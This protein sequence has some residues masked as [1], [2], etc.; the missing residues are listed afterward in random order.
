M[1]APVLV[2]GAGPAGL[3]VAGELALAGV[4]AVVIDRL[5]APDPHAPGQAINVSTVELLDERGLV[6]GLRATT[7]ALPGAHFSLLWLRPDGLAESHPHG[8][9]APQALVEAALAERLAGSAVE[10]R[11]GHLLTGLR[12]DATGVTARLRGPDG[13]YDLRGSYLVG[14]DGEDSTVRRLAGIGFPG[15]GWS[16]SGIVGDIGTDFATLPQVHLGA[17]FSEAGGMYSGSP[18]GPGVLR[19]ITAA[20]DS[21]QRTGS[22]PATLDELQ[23]EVARLTGHLLPAR[24]LLWAERFTSTTGNAERYRD[25]RVFLVGDAAHTF[26]PLG[27]L[28]LNT[29]VHDALNLGWKLAAELRGWAPPGLLDSYHAERHPVG[30]RAGRVLD[31]QLAL[32][33]PPERVAPLRDLFAEL[34]GYDD[35]NRHLLELVTGVD[36]RYPLDGAGA[37]HPLLGRRLPHLPLVTADGTDT[38]V[39]ALQRRARGVLLHLASDGAVHQDAVRG[40]SDRVDTVAVRPSEELLAATGGAAVLLRPDG[41]IAWAGA[42]GGPSLADALKSWFGAPH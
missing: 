22:G 11:R 39:A 2:I 12:Q 9:M 10:V 24:A 25:G 4:G 23:S 13:E 29:A 5:A 16:F 27:G 17:R 34:V 28:R 18:A 6:D 7:M 42:G 40:W 32:A 21:A 3:A 33:H 36:V 35:V 14:A 41:H 37:G 15:N 38:G 26:F 30:A 8:L 19:I 31:A 1:S 20:T